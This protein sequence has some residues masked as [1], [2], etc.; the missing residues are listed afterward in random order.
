[1]HNRSCGDVATY[2]SDDRKKRNFFVPSLH[3]NVPRRNFAKLY[4]TKVMWTCLRSEELRFWIVTVITQLQ[5]LNEDF[6]PCW[7]IWSEVAFWV[8]LMN[9]GLDLNSNFESLLICIILF[10]ISM[11]NFERDGPRNFKLMCPR[12][13]EWIDQY[14]PDVCSCGDL[15]WIWNT[16]QTHMQPHNTL[17]HVFQKKK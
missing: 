9:T 6:W 13:H 14:N 15:M 4:V 3:D 8:P 17:S 7:I 12:T 5:F 11:L 2:A 1:M 16:V 10:R